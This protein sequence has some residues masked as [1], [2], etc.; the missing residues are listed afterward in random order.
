[1]S[2]GSQ[3]PPG[4]PVTLQLSGN[5]TSLLAQKANRE[6]LDAL[7]AIKANKCDTEQLLV[8]QNVL[9]KQIKHLAVLFMESIRTSVEKPQDSKLTK[10]HHR[11]FLLNQ[12][13]TLV[14]SWIIKY[15]PM[16]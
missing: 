2:E 6:E 5:I 7:D 3:A 13:R 16:K 8:S 10:E 4:A 14:N 1:M 15:D 9:A 12:I 11:K